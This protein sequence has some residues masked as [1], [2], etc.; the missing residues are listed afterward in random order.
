MPV[1]KDLLSMAGA[2]K[3]WQGFMA[4]SPFRGIGYAPSTRLSKVAE[5]L[6]GFEGAYPGAVVGGASPLDNMTWGPVQRRMARAGR[7][8]DALPG[9]M[10]RNLEKHTVDEAMERMATVQYGRDMAYRESWTPT[11][12]SPPGNTYSSA[13]TLADKRIG[14]IDGLGHTG[15]SAVTR[16]FNTDFGSAR[17]GMRVSGGIAHML[18][19][20]TTQSTASVFGQKGLASNIAYTSEQSLFSN[21]TSSL[22]TGMH[23]LNIRRGLFTSG[24]MLG[25]GMFG[26]TRSRIRGFNSRRGNRIGR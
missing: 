3:M 12:K 8:L 17:T 2:S 23:D 7:I 1:S 18:A 26:G 16:S 19:C 25:G 11:S 5:D 24:G 4:G 9:S 6:S 21:K 10:S 20:S 15:S 13:P 22:M 14:A